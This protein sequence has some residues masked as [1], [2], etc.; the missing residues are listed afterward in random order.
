[1]RALYL[2]AQQVETTGKGTGKRITLATRRPTLKDMPIDDQS[3]NRKLPLLTIVNEVLSGH[4]GIHLNRHPDKYK[5]KSVNDA[6]EKT[7]YPFE[8]PF[9]L[10]HQQALLGLTGNKPALGELNY[11]LSLTLPLGHTATN[12]YGVIDQ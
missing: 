1:L 3:L 2:F 6:L 10:A 7:R 12:N 8:L 4:L 9:D 11:R 5:F